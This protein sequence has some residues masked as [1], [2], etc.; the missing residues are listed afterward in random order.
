M[1][2]VMKESGKIIIWKVW[3][4]TLGM[5]AGNMK[6]NIKMTR[7]MALVYIPGQMVVVTKDFGGRVNNMA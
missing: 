1:V 3:E 2:V 4:Y 7:N 5:M 6:A